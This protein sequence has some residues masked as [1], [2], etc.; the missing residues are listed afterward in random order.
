M[1]RLIFFKSAFFCVQAVNDEIRIIICLP[2]AL[3]LQKKQNMKSLVFTIL[4]ACTVPAFVISQD[5]PAY[6]LYN[7]KG[8]E[9]KWSKMLDDL[10]SSDVVFFGE[11]HNDPVA[12]WLELQLMKDLFV[13]RDSQMVAG[14]EMF[15]RD[16]QVIVDEFLEGMFDDSKFEED[17][18][19]WN[20]YE[21]DYRPLLDYAKENGIYFVATNV[22]RRYASMVFMGGFEALND[23]SDRAKE[24]IAPLPV[25]YDPEVGSY[26]NMMGMGMGHGSSENLPKAQALKDATMAYSISQNLKPGYL[27]LHFNGEYHS[28]NK[29]GIL[30]YLNRYNP[31][32][33]IKTVSA[34]FQKDIDNIDDD[35]VSKA[36]YIIVVPEDM[37]RTY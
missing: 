6:R 18:R 36:D 34:V 22:P 27:F 7:S 1:K 11:Q 32:L 28:Q 33:D 3:F 12:H 31:G 4:L 29:E 20:N 14:A 23:L 13:A 5:M 30:W 19:L 17:A 24:F 25:A 26:K 8:K 2:F 37:T 15:E 21:T 16:N 10:S 9:V 35:N